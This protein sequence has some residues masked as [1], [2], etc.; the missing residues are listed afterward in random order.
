MPAATWLELCRIFEG[1]QDYHRA[2]EE[3]EHLA[4]AFPAE[5]PSLLALLS[6]GRLSLKQLNRP[7]DALAYY[8]AASVS[9]VPHLDWDSNIQAGIQGAEKLLA[10]PATPA[11][12]A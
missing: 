11:T 1:K 3:Y 5:R 4:K 9:T 10:I 6:A 2:V 8:K 7:A 12:L